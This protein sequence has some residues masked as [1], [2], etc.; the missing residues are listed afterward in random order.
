[1]KTNQK[2]KKMSDFD[3]DLKDL[4]SAEDEAFIADHLEETGYY[5]EV[6]GSLKG[7]GGAMHLLTWIGILAASAGLIF[8]I[9]QFFHADT[10]RDQ[11]LYA[12]FAV[13]LNSAQIA[14]KMW[15]NM[16]LNRRAVI[17]EIKRL[18]LALAH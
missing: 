4:L 17:R 5:T 16:R 3:K 10:T 11:I 1:M 8:C 7:R 12:M 13:L 14:L 2:E 18:H 15:F 6:F 9:W